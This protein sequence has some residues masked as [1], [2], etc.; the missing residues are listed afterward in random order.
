M[1]ANTILKA[2]TDASEVQK[3]KKTNHWNS[4]VKP[5]SRTK[6]TAEMRK[7]QTGS[8]AALLQYSANAPKGIA[9]PRK[10]TEVMH[11]QT[12]LWTIGA[13]LIR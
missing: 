10:A 8:E 5:H 7:E 13:R 3:H 6:T 11:H 1:S 2:R 12:M 9:V 4:G